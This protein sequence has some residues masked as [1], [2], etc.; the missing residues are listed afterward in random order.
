MTEWWDVKV[1]DFGFSC[2]CEE[3]VMSSVIGSKY[4][5]SPE[6]LSGDRYDH[7]TDVYSFG[8]LLADIGMGGNLRKLFLKRDNGPQGM[9]LNKFLT[10]GWRPD[11][12]VAWVEE[13]PVVTDLID[14]CWERDPKDRPDFTEI[15]KI[16]SDWSGKLQ[17][18]MRESAV[19]RASTEYTDEE[20]NFIS[21]GMVEFNK[22]SLAPKRLPVEDLKN[23]IWFHRSLPDQTWNVHIEAAL[24]FP[25]W[26]VMD[27][28]I[29][30]S[31]PEKT[32]M[33]RELGE[34]SHR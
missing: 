11:L 3:E 23:R 32:A 16:L 31:N 15:R 28:I 30:W 5:M 9:D 24:E 33:L 26:E 6:M 17:R 8:S 22:L 12:P 29:D 21:E 4:Y 7:K 2:V 20:M 27:A 19:L 1:A 18:T 10:G 13:M 25:S 34:T 14:R